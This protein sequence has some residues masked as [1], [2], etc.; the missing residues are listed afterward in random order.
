M[1]NVGTVYLVGAGPGDPKL[2]T[3]R[4]REVLSRA[5]VVIYDRLIGAELLNSVRSDAEKIFVGKEAARHALPQDD[6][7]A[8]LVEH[9]VAGKSVCRLKGGDPFVFGRGG[10]EAL[11]CRAHGVPFEIVPGVSSSIAAP[12]YAGI[13][14]TQR[15]VATSFAVVTG[16]TKDD[17]APPADLPVA[18][19]LVFLMGVRALPKIVAQLLARGESADKPVALVRWGTTADQQVVT[20]TLATIEDEVQRAGLKPPALIVVGD[21]VRLRDELRWFDN[22]LLCGQTVVVTRAREQASSLVEGLQNLGAQVLQCPTIRIEELE[23]YHQLDAALADL[24]KFS[25]IVFTSVNGVEQFWKRLRHQGRDARALANLQIAAI[26]PATVEALAMRGLVADFTPSISI[27]ETVADELLAQDMS[28]QNVLIVRA[29]E[30]REVLQERLEAGGANVTLAPAYRMVPDFANAPQVRKALEENRIDWV[31]FTSSSTVRN[32]LDA[33][34]ADEVQ[35]QRSRFR[36]ACIGPVTARTATEHGL[37]PD[38]VAENASVE[39]LI[40]ALAATTQTEP[41]TQEHKDN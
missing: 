25:W 22:R 16:H 10:E 12:A 13:P 7:N 36:V 4:G 18:D 1:K 27:S 41:P 3:V 34:G 17:D 24:A 30:G 39:A 21:V 38:V 20:G 2:I 26:G 40:Q 9:A 23:D 31:T 14:V 19:T 5:D 35:S 28:A 6:I 33:L 32:F 11:F 29:L 15:D 37:T 8:L